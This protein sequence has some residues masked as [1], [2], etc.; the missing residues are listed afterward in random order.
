MQMSWALSVEFF[1]SIGKCSCLMRKNRTFAVYFVWKTKCGKLGEAG[2]HGS[3][4][5]WCVSSS[6]DISIAS[7]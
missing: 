6:I 7:V 1:S 5:G 3:Y 2:R 4:A